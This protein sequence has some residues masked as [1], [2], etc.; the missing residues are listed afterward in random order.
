MSAIILRGDA[1]HLPLPDESVVLICCSVPY[2]GLRDYQDAGESLAG[3]IG[4]ETTP[5]EYISSLLACT[6][7]WA[8]ALKPAG[9]IFVNIG[10]VYSNRADGARGR[11][12]RR[13]RPQVSP[14]ARNTTG[15]ARRKSLLGL[16]WR[17]ALGCVDELGL[18]LRRDIIWHK[19]TALPESV[20]DR[21]AT[22]HEYLFH[23]TKEPRYFAG[24][25]EIREPHE[26]RP[27][28]R[29]N[30]HRQ[31]QRLGVLPAQ[32]WSTSRRD[33]PGPDGH[34]LGRAPG[35]VWPIAATPLAVPAHIDV[36]HFAAWPMEIPRRL[37]LG[38]SAAGICTVCGEGRFPVASRSVEFDRARDQAHASEIAGRAV[39]RAG[40]LITG[41]T[42][43]STLNG[44]SLR[45]VQG[46]ACACTPFT[47]HPERRGSDFH[48][49]S[50]R[51]VQG[52]N[53]G[54]GGDRY[55]R[56]MED[57]AS[58]RG[59]VRE[60]HF[61]DWTPPPTRPSV[62]LDPFGGTGTT[63][64]V[65]DVLGRTGISVDLSADYCRLARWRTT[66]PGQRARAL[67]VPKPPPVSD[68]QLDLFGD[69]S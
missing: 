23:L 50:D 3:Q 25:D 26:M 60:Y 63:S 35:S 47:D 36:E 30:G 56:H 8:R 51:A 62:V 11:A 9:S 57:L 6:A 43:A 64:L 45:S 61:G 31:R 67:Q 33:E 5:A 14:P 59:P 54:N 19:L 53:D 4:S 20:T 32:T 46:Y 10:D 58:P 44:R 49:G 42:A 15:T 24:I 7:E 17:Y 37:I 55:S 12:W 69:V 18:I 29:P 1:G 22:R 41:G 16:P 66:D 21:V 48:A 13:E 28:R 40:G 65:A 52:M 2:Y 39:R 38:W 34:P 68:G 27:Q